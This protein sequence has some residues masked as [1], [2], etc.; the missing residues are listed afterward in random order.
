[1]TSIAQSHVVA[2]LLGSVTKAEE[3][4]AAEMVLLGEEPI[5]GPWQRWSR[6][7]KGIWLKQPWVMDRVAE[8]RQSEVDAF[9]R[10]LF[11]PHT[12]F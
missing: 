4:T 2:S 8:E 10:W 6:E 5:Q 3:R 9:S 1:M 12:I 11:I 7:Q